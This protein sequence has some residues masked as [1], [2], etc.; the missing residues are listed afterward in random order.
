MIGASTTSSWSWVPLEPLD[1][2]TPTTW[3]LVPLTRIDW[4]IGLWPANRFWTTV[5]P[6]T[7][8]RACLLTSAEVNIAPSATW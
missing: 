4:P 1:F 6:I 8:T 2:V 7:A 3:K 5:G